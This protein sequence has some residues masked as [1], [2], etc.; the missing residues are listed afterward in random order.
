MEEGQKFYCSRCRRLLDSSE[1]YYREGNVRD[2]YCKE[3]RKEYNQSYQIEK[4]G[5]ECKYEVI[6]HVKDPGKRLELA[7]AAHAKVRGLVQRVMRKRIETEG[8]RQLRYMKGGDH[9][10]N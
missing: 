8:M 9:G 1:F 10:T 7:R 4:K 3:C 6:P 5:K 2:C